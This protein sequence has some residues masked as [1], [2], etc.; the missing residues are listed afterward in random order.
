M[1]AR[2][3]LGEERAQREGDVG[4][5]WAVAVSAS[6]IQIAVAGV[7]TCD[8]G[9]QNLRAGQSECGMWPIFRA[10]RKCRHQ[11]GLKWTVLL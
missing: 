4:E 1:A 3:R 6:G 5:L 8:P 10:N 7:M 2:D 11:G 9:D